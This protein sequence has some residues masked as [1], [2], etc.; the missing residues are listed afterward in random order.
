MNSRLLQAPGELGTLSVTPVPQGTVCV[1]WL[2]L[3]T[4]WRAEALVLS[5]GIWHNI[6]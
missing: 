3:E 1:P 4:S 6:S 5:A 2:A